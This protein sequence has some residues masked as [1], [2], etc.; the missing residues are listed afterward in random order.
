[1]SK[2]VLGRTKVH[3]KARKTSQNDNSKPDQELGTDVTSPRAE[4]N[5]SYRHLSP[6]VKQQSVLN[7]VA[8]PELNQ[9][10][11]TPNDHIGP[12]SLCLY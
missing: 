8:Q 3:D 1:L 5:N 9:A 4:I 11:I 12:V 6:V 10:Y 2:V 7:N